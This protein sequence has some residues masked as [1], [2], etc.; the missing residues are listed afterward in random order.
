MGISQRDYMKESVPAYRMIREAVPILL[1]LNIAVFLCWSLGGH[2]WRSF[3]AEHFTTSL[4]AIQAGRVWT[5]LTA[6]FSHYELWHL[7]LNMF[8]LYSF[9]PPLERQWGTRTFWI[10]YLVAAVTAS[11]VHVAL[12]A[13][14]W[15]LEEVRMLGAS[16]AISG[17]LVCY[18]FLYPRH[19][20]LLFFVIPM[21]VIVAALAFVGWDLWGLYQQAIGGGGNI[22]HG[23]HLGG[24][25][26]GLVFYFFFLRRY[27]HRRRRR[28]KSRA[29][30]RE[31]PSL[32][33]DE[34]RQ[35]DYLL[36]KVHQGGLDSL[37]PAEREFMIH[38]SE[39]MRRGR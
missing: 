39:R 12:G 16:G 25:A 13:T 27:P 22:G 31:F 34:Q 38:M 24:A 14:P 33:G 11:S 37:T 15:W 30:S 10:F 9:G 28:V 17:L 21:P 1:G 26:C 5:L 19:T 20:I 29:P 6:A 2:G 8:V 3:L 23:A 7:V 35:L 36:Q 32:P 18:S 4:Q